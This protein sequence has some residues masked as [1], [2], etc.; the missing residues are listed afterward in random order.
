MGTGEHL[1]ELRPGDPLLQLVDQ[2]PDLR[3]G[4]LVLGVTSQFYE[5]P[6]VIQLPPQPVP[7]INRLLQGRPVLQDLLRGIGVIPETRL[8]NER[9][10]FL[11]I[12]PF[13]IYFKETP[14]GNGDALPGSLH[15]L[16]LLYTLQTPF[17]CCCDTTPAKRRLEKTGY[18]YSRADDQADNR[19]K[20]PEPGIYR[21]G[22]SRPDF[23]VEK[24]LFK[25]TGRAG[26]T[27]VFV[28]DGGYSG[29]GGPQQG[30]PV[31]NGAKNRHGKVLIRGGGPAIP[32]IVG[33]IDQNPRPGPDVAA[34]QFREDPLKTDENTDFTLA[35]VKGD[36]GC[37]RGEV[38]H[39][40]H[41]LI[42]EWK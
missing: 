40:H 27:P 12:L 31:L 3:E 28:D 26:D 32:G 18:G 30:H 23:P 13:A 2:R 17:L 42:N 15:G 16:F 37:A 6:C 33:N 10:Q 14:E 20:V 22:R 39:P 11:D 34:G 19:E 24:R 35:R 29:V 21:A 5:N 41:Q 1:P 7:S 25:E 38:P 4:I 9:L 8:R 36:N